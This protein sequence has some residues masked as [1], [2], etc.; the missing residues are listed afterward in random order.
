VIKDKRLVTPTGK[1]NVYNTRT[2]S[3][4]GTVTG[5]LGAAS[6]NAGRPFFW[7]KGKKGTFASIFL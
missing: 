2:T 1:F 3:T 5:P 7:E 4:D 6:R